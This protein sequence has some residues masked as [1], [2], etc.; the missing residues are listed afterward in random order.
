MRGRDIGH[1][2]SVLREQ[3]IPYVKPEDYDKT[4]T[5]ILTFVIWTQTVFTGGR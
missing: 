2:Q 3:T 5:K 1:Q 4:K